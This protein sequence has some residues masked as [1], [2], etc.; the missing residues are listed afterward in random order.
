M[1]NPDQKPI[2]RFDRGTLLLAGVSR[3]QM[4]AALCSKPWMWDSRVGQW[5]CEAIRYAE[6]LKT[7]EES[8]GRIDDLAPAWVPVVPPR[9]Q[10]HT[11]R[12]EQEKALGRGWLPNGA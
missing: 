5:R 8:H 10:L 9:L 3:E 11:L 4:P 12:E 6:A 7:L 1:L 2:L